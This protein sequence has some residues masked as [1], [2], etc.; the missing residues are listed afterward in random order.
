M[1][2]EE[3]MLRPG[4]TCWRTAMADRA[5]VLMDN[6]PYYEALA[7]ALPKARRSIHIL[8]WTFDPRTVL[9]PDGRGQPASEDGRVGR[10]LIALAQARPELD[11]RI[12]CWR[13]D[14]P[15]AATQGFYPQR[16]E[17]LF[18]DTPVRFRLEKALP[19]GACHHQKVVV[20]DDQVAFSG[21][22]DISVDRWDSLEHPDRDGRRT[23]P[24]GKE[25]PP[26]HDVM[27]VVSGPAAQM[28]GDL[29]R[30]RWLA[31]FDEVLGRTPPGDGDAWPDPV[32]PEYREVRIGL[33]R[34]EPAW[35]GDPGVNESERLHL[36]AIASARR[37]LIFEN[38]YVASPVI[39]TALARRLQD[40]DGPE[41]V[42]L[43]TLRSPSWFDQMT[44]DRTRAA[45][46]GRLRAFDVYGRF[47][48]FCPVTEGG[49]GIIV[50]SKVTIVDDHHLR[51]GSANLNNR[52]FGFDTECDLVIEADRPEDRAQIA[53]YRLKMLA[54]WLGVKESAFEREDELGGPGVIEALDRLSVKT[55]RLVPVENYRQTWLRNTI[56]MN[57]LGDPVDPTDSWQPWVR[58]RKLSRRTRA[59]LGGASP[60]GR[61][62]R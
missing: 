27:A 21:G 17:G 7:A 31:A 6:G 62:R 20:I 38:Q 24:N 39:E 47:R 9:E 59:L 43:T 57:H 40:L 11:V 14:L 53:A 4:D 18:R 2:P 56:A 55:G 29:F 28:L 49:R 42:I 3:S 36:A 15:I 54:H 50:H 37:T 33:S 19:I 32:K 5:A 41:I 13:M 22:C 51:I 16:A 26:R 30:R 34:T 52:S 25:H 10:L 45:M 46:V 12:L 23:M 48:A 58:F 61:N 44:M 1:T 60:A 35:G 8:G